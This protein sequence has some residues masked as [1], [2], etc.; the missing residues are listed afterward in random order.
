MEKISRLLGKIIEFFLFVFMIILVSVTF[1]QVFCRF[2]IKVPVS[3]SQEVVK[4]SF[5]WI[6][7]LGAAIAVRENTHLCM[8]IV[9]AHLPSSARKITKI[10]IYILSL[11]CALFMLYGGIRYCIQCAAKSMMTLPLPADVQYA[12]MPVGAGLMI[13]Y[14]LEKA[15]TYLRERKEKM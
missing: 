14:L 4:L 1:L 7:F 11:V 13:W 12:A 10:L 3:W 6:I 8:D 9:T 2:V 5:V 15:G